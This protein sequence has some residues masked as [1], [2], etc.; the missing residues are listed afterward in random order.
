MTTRIEDDAARVYGTLLKG[1]LVVL[2]TDIGYGLVAIQESAVNRIYELKGRP[3]SK[4]CV[5]VANGTIFDEVTLPI[6]PALRRWLEDVTTRTPLA[7][8]TQ[9]NPDSRLLRSMS[10]YVVS[11][12]TQDG[13]I[14]TFH[15]AGQLVQRVANL[16]LAD[17]LLVVGSSANLS[18][19]GNNYTVEEVPEVMR[20]A[21][22]LVL[23]TN[24]PHHADAQRCC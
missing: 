17:G 3:L 15:A 16:A 12:A 10:P 23:E 11:Q 21:A 6:E 18:C 24:Q 20:L 13:T 4:P 8:V 19:T 1:G 5:T 2:P 7:V 14:A 22:D 9:L